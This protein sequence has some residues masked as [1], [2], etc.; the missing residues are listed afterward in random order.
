MAGGGRCGQGQTE[1]HRRGPRSRRPP[2]S[3]RS[4]GSNPLSSF[5]SS[6]PA[7]WA[8]VAHRGVGG[9]G[10][11][12]DRRG[13]LVDR[14]RAAVSLL[15]QHRG[16]PRR[17]RFRRNRTGPAHRRTPAV[18]RNHRPGRI[19][20]ATSGNAVRRGLPAHRHEAVPSGA[21][22]ADVLLAWVVFDADTVS[23]EP[24]S[25]VRSRPSTSPATRRGCR[26]VTTG[27]TWVSGS[28]SAALRR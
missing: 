7:S 11:P 4:D 10:H 20:T 25:P 17:E 9:R 1:G 24:M 14:T 19:R 22:V 23:G 6:C 12:V 27:T 18:P 13:G 3:T 2:R 8:A 5:A 16:D 28:P 21:A 26:S 15:R